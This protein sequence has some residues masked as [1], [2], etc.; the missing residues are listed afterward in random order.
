MK[1]VSSAFLL[2]LTSVVPALAGVANP[3]PEPATMLVVGGALAATILVVRKRRQ[4]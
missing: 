1:I 3:V 4:K 2:V